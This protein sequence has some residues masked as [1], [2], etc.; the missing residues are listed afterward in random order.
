VRLHGRNYKNW[1]SKTADVRERY[2]HLYSLDELAPWVDRTKGIA[3][4]AK[5]T[6]VLSNHNIGKAAVNSLDIRAIFTGQPVKVRPSLT[7]AYPD[8]EAVAE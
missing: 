3:R 7:L 2:D 1:C 8:L 5:D 6:Y 4:H